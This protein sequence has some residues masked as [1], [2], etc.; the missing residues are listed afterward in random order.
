MG[1]RSIPIWL[2]TAFV[3]FGITLI[4]VTMVM[5][6]WPA[7]NILRIQVRLFPS[8][9]FHPS[10]PSATTEQLPKSSPP[11]ACRE[12]F[13]QNR[14]EHRHHLLVIKITNPTKSIALTYEKM[15]Y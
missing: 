3:L 15:Y 12:F 14:K 1:K 6:Y 11:G 4:W 7:E 5:A 8:F 2:I 10:Y 9:P 13:L